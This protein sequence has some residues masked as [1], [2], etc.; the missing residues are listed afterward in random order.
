M[1]EG[2]DTPTGDDGTTSLEDRVQ[3][4]KST[5][6]GGNDNRTGSAGQA[7]AQVHPKDK[8][9]EEPAG[10]RGTIGEHTMSGINAASSYSGKLQS[11]VTLVV[12]KSNSDNDENGWHKDNNSDCE[13]QADDKAATLLVTKS[14]SDND[15][16]GWHKHNN[17]DC[18]YQV[19]DYKD[20]FVCLAD[21]LTQ[22]DKNAARH[23][24]LCTGNH[25]WRNGTVERQRI[26]HKWLGG[27]T[28]LPLYLR[29]TQK[30]L[31]H[32]QDC[33]FAEAMAFNSGKATTAAITVQGH[34]T[35][36]GQLS[37]RS[38]PYPRAHLNSGERGGRTYQVK[39]CQHLGCTFIDALKQAPG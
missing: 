25:R 1:Q 12:T 17:S 29:S 15:E 23:N 22:E 33:N 9:A 32:L 26:M 35:Q 38:E 4:S 36:E 2:H 7:Q 20:L 37:S 34:H 8:F 13:Y 24:C 31:M 27:S 5:H 19:D 11:P 14:N 16:N 3:D 39:D 21:G 18:E 30:L 10:R 28:V 6:D